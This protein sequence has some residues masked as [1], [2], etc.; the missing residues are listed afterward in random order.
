M[1][2]IFNQIDILGFF[3]SWLPYQVMIMPIFNIS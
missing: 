1:I 2:L 3:N